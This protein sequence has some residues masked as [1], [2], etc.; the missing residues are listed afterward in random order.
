M[1][2]DLQE[3]RKPFKPNKYDVFVSGYNGT[4]HDPVYI[5]LVNSI[6]NLSPFRS[7]QDFKDAKGT[8]ISRM[9]WSVRPSL[10]TY[11]RAYIAKPRERRRGSY[12]TFEKLNNWGVRNQGMRYQ[13]RR[14][15]T[16]SVYNGKCAKKG[17]S[18]CGGLA[19]TA[20][21][22]FKGFSFNFFLPGSNERV[23]YMS[24][25]DR[26]WGLTGKK[27]RFRLT[28]LPGADVLMLTQLVAFI[29]L[30][31]NDEEVQQ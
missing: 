21:G 8:P 25:V 26:Y 28:V 24:M 23:A 1:T 22:H 27:E 7:H 20:I 17:S 9:H 6:V 15:E 2:V 18:K 30:C 10:R 3:R 13:A 19:L 12:Y 16:F 14:E 4:Q 29:D 31:N 11:A 5:G